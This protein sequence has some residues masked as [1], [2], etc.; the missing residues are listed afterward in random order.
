MGGPRDWFVANPGKCMMS[1][2]GELP[3]SKATADQWLLAMK[4]ALRAAH[5]DSELAEMLNDAFGRMAG[6]MARMAV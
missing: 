5:V 3:I 1:L 2:H 4:A 6:A